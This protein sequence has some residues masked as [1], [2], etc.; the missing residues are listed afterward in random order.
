M[1][2]YNCGAAIPEGRDTCMSCGATQS[3]P[4]AVQYGG[5]QG[6][7]ASAQNS[8]DAWAQRVRGAEQPL[9]SIRGCRI[10][11]MII[12]AIIC[13]AALIYLSALL[14]DVEKVS[15]GSWGSYYVLSDSYKAK[16]GLYNV[17]TLICGLAGIFV[18]ICT[19]VAYNNMKRFEDRYGTVF[20]LALVSIITGLAETFCKD[21]VKILFSLADAVVEILLY[22]HFCGAMA[23]ITRPLNRDH[24]SK[25]DN[26][27]KMYVAYC[28]L[29]FVSGLIIVAC[30]T[31][32]SSLRGAMIFFTLIL[33]GAFAIAVYE[34]R[35]LKDSVGIFA[36]HSR[37]YVAPDPDRWHL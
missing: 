8:A 13:G 32:L 25:W 1:F 35:L 33:A 12:A 23:D 20:T 9:N 11:G 17:I 21:S 37:R 5:A 10:A 28:A 15:Y 29:S 27:F 19:L 16:E 36:I 22:Y 18:T 31:S 34:V 4:V 6:G 3:R 30:A 14:H 26:L 24:A 7:M 2:C